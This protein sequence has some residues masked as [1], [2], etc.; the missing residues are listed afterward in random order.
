MNRIAAALA[1]EYP[2]YQE[3][4]EASFQFAAG[5]IGQPPLQS[6]HKTITVR[7]ASGK[8]AVSVTPSGITYET[9][10]YDSR[11]TMLAH[12]ETLLSAA[13]PV[14]EAASFDRIGVRYSNLFS[15]DQQLTHNVRSSLFE[16]EELATEGARLSQS[17]S[18]AVYA[19]DAATSLLVRS[20]LLPTNV[21]ID[22]GIVV[23]VDGPGVFLLDLDSFTTTPTINTGVTAVLGKVDELAQR[24]A[25]YFLWSLKPAGAKALG[26]ASE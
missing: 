2:T 18:E 16:A 10:E 4:V 23:P 19:I 9:G 24:A 12:L 3:G 20:A 11:R 13:F 8:T 26:A 21:S 6:T 15:R 25:G 22:P 7:T 17:V 14:I 5:G 1:P